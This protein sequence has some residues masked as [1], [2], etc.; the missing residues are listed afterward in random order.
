M[1]QKWYFADAEYS[2]YVYAWTAPQC[3]DAEEIKR[4]AHAWGDTPEE[5][6]GMMHEATPEEIQEYGR[7]G[8][9]EEY[10]ERVDGLEGIRIVGFLPLEYF[11]IVDEQLNAADQ[12]R[13]DKIIEAML[14]AGV[15]MSGEELQAQDSY[16]GGDIDTDKLVSDAYARLME[17]GKAGTIEDDSIITARYSGWSIED[18]R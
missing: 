15:E 8:W 9:S 14:P 2:R 13:F 18:M 3:I 5:I 10:G 17:A 16:T 7:V 12:A 6:R 4:I 11:E 1:G